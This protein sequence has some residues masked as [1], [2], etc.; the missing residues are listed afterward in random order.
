MSCKEAMMPIGSDVNATTRPNP[1]GYV[2]KGS[3]ADMIKSALASNKKK[4]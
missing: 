4:R 2:K 1:G 3:A